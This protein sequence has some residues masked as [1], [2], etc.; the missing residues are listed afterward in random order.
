[1]L[2]I[3]AFFS[4]L[5]AEN[6][7]PAQIG[8]VFSSSL[9]QYASRITQYE[10]NWLHLTLLKACLSLPKGQACFFKLTTDLP[11]AASGFA[12]RPQPKD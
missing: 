2:K 4:R 5:R 8:F 3:K 11:S 7:F 9:S 10:I 6:N 1:L 12:L